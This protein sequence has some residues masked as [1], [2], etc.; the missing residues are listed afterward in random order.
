MD[1]LD[2]I[3]HLT[4]PKKNSELVLEIYELYTLWALSI[5]SHRS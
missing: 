5:N 3:H 4:D 2:T 1:P